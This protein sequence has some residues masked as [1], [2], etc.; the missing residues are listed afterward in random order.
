MEAI[1][2]LMY[3]FYSA[4]IHTRYQL[5]TDNKLICHKNRAKSIN[6]VVT[7]LELDQTMSVMGSCLD[8]FTL[9]KINLNFVI[10]AKRSRLGSGSLDR[11]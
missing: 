1:R 8:A 3:A 11:I 10:V 5:S 7:C 6:H 2:L 4:F 9:D